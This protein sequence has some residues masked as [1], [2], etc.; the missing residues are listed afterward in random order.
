LNNSI[1]ATTRFF[2]IVT[3]IL[4]EGDFKA[5]NVGVVSGSNFIP[6]PSH[7]FKFTITYERF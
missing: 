2:E 7:L 6:L 4:N 1:D 3:H 5:T